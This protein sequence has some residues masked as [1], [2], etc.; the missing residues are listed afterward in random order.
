MKNE[1]KTEPKINKAFWAF[2]IILCLGLLFI[3]ISV[4]L[5]T[6]YSTYGKNVVGG[7]G[8]TGFIITDLC[9]L[10]FFILF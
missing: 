4:G 8:L 1:T 3:I 9:L 5:S 10:A 2:F 6:N 7:L